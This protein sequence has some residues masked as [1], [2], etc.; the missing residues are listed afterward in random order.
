MPSNGITY[1]KSVSPFICSKWWM[2]KIITVFSKAYFLPALESKVA[3]KYDKCTSR[4]WRKWRKRKTAYSYGRTQERATLAAVRG[5]NLSAALRCH[6][7]NG[8]YG[9]SELRF[10]KA[11]TFLRNI[12]SIWPCAFENVRQPRLRPKTLKGYRLL[13]APNY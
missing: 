5:A 7:N 9:A 12:S 6:G 11:E 3:S 13:M 4:C 10:P 1:R 8:K 2:C